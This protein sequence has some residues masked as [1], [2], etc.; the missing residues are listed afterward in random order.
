MATEKQQS[1]DAVGHSH[2]HDH[3]HQHGQEEHRNENVERDDNHDPNIDIDTTE[4]QGGEDKKQ[5]ALKP[6]VMIYL[7]LWLKP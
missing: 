6:F 1:V 5:A 4:Q 2:E 7:I 3:G